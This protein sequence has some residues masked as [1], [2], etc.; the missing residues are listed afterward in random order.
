MF[1]I[2]TVQS[3]SK[4]GAMPTSVCLNPGMIRPWV[5]DSAGIFGRARWPVSADYWAWPVVVPT[6]NWDAFLSNLVTG[7]LGAR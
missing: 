6:L 2:V 4:M 7:A 3:A 5:G 1:K